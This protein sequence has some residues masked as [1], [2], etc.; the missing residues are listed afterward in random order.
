MARKYNWVF[1]LLAALIF[2]SC[3]TKITSYQ[4]TEPGMALE[5]FF[6]GELFAYGI[7]QNRFG[8]VQKRFTVEMIAN[9]EGSIGILEEDFY[10]ADGST[11]RRVWRLVKEA[12]NRYTG[13]AADVTVDAI[14]QTS[15]FAF[16]WGYV[17]DVPIDGK[18]WKFKLNDWM[19][20]V[21]EK[22]LINRAEMKKF[23]FVVGEI[24]LVI[25]KK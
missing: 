12:Q 16:Q 15:G 18:I 9:W 6:D 10:Y 17:L 25:E 22:R 1:V 8:K 2:S 24:T 19:Y 20:L 5:E 4:E 13:T 11:D 3:A 14:G 7:V 21:D 23:G